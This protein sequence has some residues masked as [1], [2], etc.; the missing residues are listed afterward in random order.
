MAAT[1]SR[2]ATPATACW[3]PKLGAASSDVDDDDDVVAAPTSD[4]VVSVEVPSPLSLVAAAPS[5]LPSLLSVEGGSVVVVMVDSS[6]VSDK[7]KRSPPV[8]EGNVSRFGT[9]WLPSVRVPGPG[10]GTGLREEKSKV[11]R[12]EE[13]RWMMVGS[14]GLVNC[15]AWWGLFWL[16][17]Y[18]CQWMI[19]DCRVVER[20]SVGHYAGFT[21]AAAA[22]ASKAR[23]HRLVASWESIEAVFDEESQ[24]LLGVECVDSE[25]IDG[26]SRARCWDIVLRWEAARGAAGWTKLIEGGGYVG[27]VCLAFALA[28]SSI[29]KHRLAQ[30]MIR[31]S[32]AQ[33]TMGRA[34]ALTKI[35]KWRQI[36]KPCTDD[37]SSVECA[38]RQATAW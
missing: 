38:R 1:P 5:L 4:P 18:G 33:S 14:T 13:S 6:C 32:S 27:W 2:A 24:Y 35:N 3:G 10:S 34:I 15:L 19:F 26:I 21:A 7:V 23:R 37:A 36:T 12:A 17:L 16:L 29:V 28:S 20:E 11:G 8:M 9:D 25:T 31:T 22:A 30:V